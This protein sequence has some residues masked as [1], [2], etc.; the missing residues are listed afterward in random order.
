MN[1]AVVAGETWDCPPTLDDRQVMDFCR[2]GYVMLEGVVPDEINR[3]TVEFLDEHDSPEPSEILD[4]NWFDE[5]VIRNPEA[6]GAVRSLLGRDFVLPEM[7]AN[8]RVE[9]PAPAL[10][11]HQDGGSMLTPRVDYLQVFYYPE[12]VPREMGPT[13]ILP[14]SHLKRGYGGI[15][16]RLR[17]VRDSFLTVA[18][19]GTIFLTCYTIWHRR[20]ASTGSGIRNNLKYNYWR[21]SEPCRDWKTDHRLQ[22]FLAGQR[23]SRVHRPGGEDARLAVRRGVGAHGRAGVALFLGESPR[24]RPAGAPLRF[25]PGWAGVRASCLLPALAVVLGGFVRVVPDGLPSRC[26][27]FEVGEDLSRVTKPLRGYHGS[28]NLPHSMN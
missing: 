26:P 22:L 19:A 1:G 3:R 27:P 23:V 21:T 18:A 10:N 25:S 24:P 12:E 15:L 20:S 28:L 2:R 8:H 13:E 14:G 16:S 17:S 9:C 11:W 5:G 4:E 6:A 7:T